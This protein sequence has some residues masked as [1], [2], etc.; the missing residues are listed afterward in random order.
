M[1]NIYTYYIYNHVGPPSDG[2]FF[3]LASTIYRDGDYVLIDNIGTQPDNRLDPGYTLICDTRNVNSMCCRG[4]DNNN[5]GALGDWYYN[6]G[7]TK[8]HTNRDSGDLNDIFVR[9]GHVQ[10]VRL[11]KK[12]NP[13]GPV[14]EYRCDVPDGTTGANISATINIVAGKYG[15]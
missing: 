2:L 12:G 7:N 9:V 15:Y 8:V 4:M 14:G 10:Q 3:Q 13:S 11:S 6:L 1:S 5:G